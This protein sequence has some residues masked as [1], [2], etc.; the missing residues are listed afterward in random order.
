MAIQN[1]QTNAQKNTQTSYD[2]NVDYSTKIKEAIQ[3]GDYNA[4][5]QYEQ[6]RNAKI[7]GMG[8]NYEKTNNYPVQSA[9]PQQ[10][11]APGSIA[12]ANPNRLTAADIENMYTQM[13]TQQNAQVDYTVQ[14]AVNE[15]TRA[16]EDA[17]KGFDQ[18]RNQV[19]IDEAQAR[20]R[21][22]LYAAAR[23]DRGGITARQYDS[24]ANTAASNRRAIEQQR[25]QLATETARQAADLRARGEFEKANA[26]LQ[27]SQERLAKLFKLQQYNDQIAITEKE[28]A[29]SEAALTGMYN[30]EKTFASQQWDY[31]TAQSEKEWAYQVAMQAIQLG[32]TPSADVLT[33]AG[34]DPNQAAQMAA[35]YKAQIDT[36]LNYKQGK[37]NQKSTSAGTG[38][39]GT[40][41][42]ANLYAIEDEASAYDYLVR[43]GKMSDAEAMNYMDYWYIYQDSKGP[44][45][46]ADTGGLGKGTFDNTIGGQSAA[47]YEAAG[48]NY[49][50]IQARL[51]Q[52][53]ASGVSTKAILAAI[54][55]A[56]QTGALNSGDYQ[57]LYNRYRG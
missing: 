9:A 7:D 13:Q 52:M 23:G 12:A 21:Q 50:T 55:D 34:L 43:I 26:V 40:F 56:Y 47:D 51:D 15:L 16:Q 11:T 30:G 14:Q 6:Q 4:A 36:D 22:V 54:S 1:G 3:A 24:I 53:K 49:A 57:R 41:S 20:D 8:L 29:M 39:S 44:A 2:P 45:S 37:Y 27:L 31:Q 17:Q 5:S 18:Q 48:A 10:A 38:D 19:N 33:A 35:V 42:L 46:D 25:Q 32:Q 28:L